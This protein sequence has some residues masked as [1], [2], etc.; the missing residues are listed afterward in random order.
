MN[1]HVT[2]LSD[3]GHREVLARRYE[4]LTEVCRVALELADELAA[5]TK[6]ADERREVF[7]EILNE[8]GDLQIAVSVQDPE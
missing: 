1:Y 3:D 7:V 2:V 8:E 4:D 6:H 5:L